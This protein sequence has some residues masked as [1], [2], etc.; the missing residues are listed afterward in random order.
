MSEIK[1]VVETPAVPATS[2]VRVI[3]VQCDVCKKAVGEPTYDDKVQWRGGGSIN[4]TCVGMVEGYPVPDGGS[5]TCQTWHVCPKCFEVHLVPF[6]EK[7][8]ATP[9]QKEIDW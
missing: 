7:L 5:K 3:G 1:K 8:G 6:L 2:Q 9:T 4:Q